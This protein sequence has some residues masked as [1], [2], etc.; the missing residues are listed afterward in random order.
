MKSLF[1][2]YLEHIGFATTRSADLD[3]AIKELHYAF[4]MLDSQQ[5]ELAHEK[6][7]CMSVRDLISSFG[8]IEE[9]RKDFVND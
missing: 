2:K 7:L 5:L 8:A 3:E 6:L 4:C 1:R 9:L